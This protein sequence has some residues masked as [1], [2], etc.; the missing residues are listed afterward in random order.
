MKWFY[1]SDTN[2]SA[3][4][5]EGFLIEKKYS[6]QS[7]YK[8]ED[9]H[10][11][12]IENEKSV[13]FLKANIK[14]NVYELCQEISVLYP[15]VYVILIVPDNMENIKKAMHVGASDILRTSSEEEEII[16]VILQAEKYMKHR[17]SKEKTYSINIAKKDCRVISVSSPKGGVGR[18]SL[19]VNM[20]TAFAKQGQKVAV[21]DGNLQF[22]DVALYFDSKP[23]KTIYEWVKEAYGRSHYCIDQYM[24]NHNSG[25]SVFAAPLRPEFFEYIHV[26]HIQS[27]I[28]EMKKLFDVI[29]IDTPGYLSDIELISLKSSEEILVV[30]TNDIPVLRST[31]LYVDTLN[32]INLKGKVKLVANRVVKNKGID[33][34]KIEEILGL[35]LFLTL[36][37]QEGIVKNSINEG[38]PYILT[39]TRSPISKAVLQLTE[40]LTNNDK[41]DGLLPRKKERKGFLIKK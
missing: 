30:I 24:V 40:I 28:E 20:A 32:S 1:Y 16:E 29:L 17:A 39:Q 21:I 11:I 7:I 10:Q 22:G 36:P 13:L 19:V 8:I 26:E 23:T 15:H 25:V 2:M 18:T 37:D 34:K 41:A 3:D 12:L 27:A 5:I 6:L 38:I 9:M 4:E 31:K 35:K 33:H 14:Y